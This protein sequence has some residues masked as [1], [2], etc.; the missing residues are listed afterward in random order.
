M[1]RVANFVV[2]TFSRVYPAGRIDHH[3]GR[4]TEKVECGEGCIVWI[5]RAF[6]Q[7]VDRELPGQLELFHVRDG[8]FRVR[9]V[10]EDADDLDRL[11]F[12]GLEGLS[13][14]TILFTVVIVVSV[15][16]DDNYLSLEIWC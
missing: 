16:V 8:L 2:V 7:C 1:Y 3:S 13:Q 6:G 15:E 12:E 14:F 4:G 10:R 11:P 9:P 5:T